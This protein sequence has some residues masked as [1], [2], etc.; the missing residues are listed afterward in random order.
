[1]VEPVI[2]K[3]QSSRAAWIAAAIGLAFIGI[4]ARDAV[5]K[6]S[7]DDCKSVTTTLSNG[8]V[9]NVRSCS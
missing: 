4:A 5:V 6:L 8:A 7:N 9:Q 2:P 1:M 3:P